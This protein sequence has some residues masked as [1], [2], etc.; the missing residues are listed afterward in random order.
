M[1][2]KQYL[3]FLVKDE[4]KI[5]ILIFVILTLIRFL[6]EIIEPIWFPLLFSY[7]FIP[8]IIVKKDRW[9]D[10]GLKRPEKLNYIVIGS[11]LAIAVKTITIVLLFY[12]YKT[13]SL[14]WMYSIAEHYKR[15][16]EMPI[17]IILVVLLFTIGVPLA[18]EVFFR[19]LQVSMTKRFTSI[20]ALLIAAFL[21]ALSHIDK[22]LISFSLQGMLL[23][24]IPIFIYGSVHAW[25]FYKTKSTYASMISHIIGNAAEAII[26]T[27]FFI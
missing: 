16:P 25:V 18:E 4:F 19:M 13:T 23:R 27:L 26:L 24:L 10:I 17:G 11:I 9:R 2:E 22:Y 7:A 20:Q 15:I 6:G 21:F 8:L 12:F 5:S 1:T 14:N 3:R